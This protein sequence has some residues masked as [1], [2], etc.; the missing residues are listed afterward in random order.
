M[1]EPRKPQPPTTRT[2]PRL[3]FVS[4]LAMLKAGFFLFFYVASI[5]G[6]RAVG[7]LIFFNSYNRVLPYVS[8]FLRVFIFNFVSLRNEKVGDFFAEEP[9][10][11]SLPS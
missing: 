1:C 9:G 5:F 11:G 2:E 4:G 10:K 6:F 7:L 3:N 8:F